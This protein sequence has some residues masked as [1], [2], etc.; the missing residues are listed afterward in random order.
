MNRAVVA[1]LAV[2]AVLC[3]AGVASAAQSCVD[4]MDQG[5][6]TSWTT[7]VGDDGVQRC[8]R[9]SNTPGSTAYE[10]TCSG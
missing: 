1:N 7:C 5:D 6:G 10:V 8:Y 3:M 2:V 4:W 9:I